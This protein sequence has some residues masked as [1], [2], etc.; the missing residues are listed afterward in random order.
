V[1]EL[2]AFERVDLKPGEARTVTFK[3][4]KSALSYFDPAKNGWMAE[5]GAFEV[6]AGSSSRD[7]RLRGVFELTK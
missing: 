6:Q 4:D 5:P 1:K 3:L 2:K 7:I